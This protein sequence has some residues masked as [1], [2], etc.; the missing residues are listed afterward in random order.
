MDPNNKREVMRITPT[1]NICT[2][3]GV[4]PSIITQAAPPQRLHVRPNG[5]YARGTFVVI[6]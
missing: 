6:T 3:M 2:K 5:G 1:C 4:A